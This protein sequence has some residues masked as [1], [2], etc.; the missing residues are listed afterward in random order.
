MA[1]YHIK[2]LSVTAITW[3]TPVLAPVLEVAVMSSD[4]DLGMLTDVGLSLATVAALA[5]PSGSV[6]TFMI[7]IIL[8]IMVYQVVQ[9]AVLAELLR[10]GICERLIHY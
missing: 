1:Q 2:L 6:I 9:S 4:V 8:T 7:A 5:T 3:A 10:Y